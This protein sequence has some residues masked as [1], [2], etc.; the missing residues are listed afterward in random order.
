MEALI[1]L[2]GGLIGGWFVPR[3]PKMVAGALLLA[4]LYVGAVVLYALSRGY[5]VDDALGLLLLINRP[6]VTQPGLSALVVAGD[7]W[8]LS[9]LVS[10]VRLFLGQR[11]SSA[12]L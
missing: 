6:E 8:V 5:Q 2:V 12:V 10:A 7:I 9:A 1:V 11:N 3:R 4:G